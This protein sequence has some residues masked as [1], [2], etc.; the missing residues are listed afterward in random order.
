MEFHIHQNQVYVIYWPESYVF[1]RTRFRFWVSAG[2]IIQRWNHFHLSCTWCAASPVFVFRS[3]VLTFG[4]WS[5]QRYDVQVRFVISGNWMFDYPMQAFM[6][7]MS[8]QKNSRNLRWS[9][10]NVVRSRS[11]GRRSIISCASNIGFLGTGARGGVI[12]SPL[13]PIF[14]SNPSP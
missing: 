8:K 10:R 14:Q 3:R 9:G 4:P 7:W 11:S 13:D 12:S 1:L 6:E 2:W 5:D